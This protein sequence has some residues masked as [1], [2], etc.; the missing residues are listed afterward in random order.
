[1]SAD[2]YSTYEAKARFAE[3]LKKVREGRTVTITYHG[4]PVAELRPYRKAEGIGERVSRLREQG[5]IYGGGA[6]GK[7]TALEKRPGALDRFLEERE[8]DD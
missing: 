2:E 3:V 5:R 6:P 4:E 1:M 8:Q 7:L